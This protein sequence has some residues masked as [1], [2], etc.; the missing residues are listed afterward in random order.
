[1]YFSCLFLCLAATPVRFSFDSPSPVITY[2][3]SSALLRSTLPEA[4]ALRDTACGHVE[5]GF[6]AKH[7]MLAKF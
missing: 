7:N 2:K 4:A 6:D 1:M 5:L 3:I